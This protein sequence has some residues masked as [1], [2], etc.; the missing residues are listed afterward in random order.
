MPCPECG[1]RFRMVESG[2]TCAASNDFKDERGWHHHDPNYHYKKY[3]CEN[4]HEFRLA[5][6]I[7]CP[8]CD[9]N[10]E[11]EDGG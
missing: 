6:K 7:P 1:A 9:F 8:A 3:R 2:N 5:F 4:G 11:V 10:R